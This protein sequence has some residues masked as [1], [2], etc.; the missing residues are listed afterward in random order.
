MTDLQQCENLFPS[1]T[2]VCVKQAVDRRGRIV[3]T[4]VVGVV[5]DWEKK[6]T[7]SWYA[8]GQYCKYW[9]YRLKL[10][11]PDGELSLIKIDD[12]TEIAKLESSSS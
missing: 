8:H 3:Q 10:R 1:G 9:L 6:P 7:G 12:D 11:K 4:E 2:P 5:E